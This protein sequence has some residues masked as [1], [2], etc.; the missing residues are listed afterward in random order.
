MK[1]VRYDILINLHHLTPA[2]VLKRDEGFMSELFRARSVGCLANTSSSSSSSSSNDARFPLSPNNNT[3]NNTNNSNNTNNINSNNQWYGRD[4]AASGNEGLSLLTD[5]DD[6]VEGIAT[7][8]ITSSTT[9]PT[10]RTEKVLKDRSA[11]WELWLSLL[12]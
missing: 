11:I 3:H 8:F 4:R 6:D 9:T 7:A 10:P 5:D 2:P 1:L 12:S